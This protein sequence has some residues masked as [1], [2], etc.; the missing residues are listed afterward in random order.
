ML[1]SL[2]IF[3]VLVV[4]RFF[5]HVLQHEHKDFSRI[6][7]LMIIELVVVVGPRLGIRILTR[8]GMAMLVYSGAKR[9][10]MLGYHDY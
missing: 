9:D 1:I 6:K 4:D 2:P 5:P 8:T 7:P 10:E 3:I